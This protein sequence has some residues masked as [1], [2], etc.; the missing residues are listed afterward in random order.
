MPDC[1]AATFEGSRQP[2]TLRRLPLPD[3]KDGEALVRVECCTLCGSDLHTLDGR[4][5]SPVPTILGHEAV[6]RIERLPPGEKLLAHDGSTLQ[7]GDR[8]TW[9]I[10]AH[11]GK[12]RRCRRGWPQKCETLF[13]YGH[14]PLGSRSALFGGMA[15]FVHLVAGTSIF[16]LPDELPARVLCPANCALATVMAVFRVLGNVSD[17]VVLIQGAGML[18]LAAVTLARRGGAK[19]IIVT[20]PIP[21]RLRWA[22][23]LGATATV[24]VSQE[25]GSLPEVVH[26]L[27]NGEGVDAAADFSGSSAAIEQALPLLGIG[28]RYALAGAVL[29]GPPVSLLAEQAVRRCLRIEGVHNYTP[30]DLGDALVFLENSAKEFP[31]DELISPEYALNELDAALSMARS[32]RFAR[33]AIAPGK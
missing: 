12:C 16:R 10:M 24:N 22:E 29:P 4:R 30:T 26:A 3:L 19:Q 33:V 9:T 27:S 8:V 11:C 17:E 6:G 7:T 14:E 5:E 18:G 31:W 20:D 2:L 28:A 25:A 15:Q 32:G 13:K 21:A 23:R 1:L